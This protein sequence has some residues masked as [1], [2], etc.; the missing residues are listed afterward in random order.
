MD[1]ILLWSGLLVIVGLG[2]FG[3][4]IFAIRDNFQNKFWK[5]MTQHAVMTITPM[6]VATFFAFSSN[7]PSLESASG[8]LRA[9]AATAV[10]AAFMNVFYWL[11]TIA[12]EPASVFND[13]DIEYLSSI[14]IGK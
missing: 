6:F 13:D 7:Q 4:T 8:F 10:T 1:N 11:N 12:G 5:P 2:G 9:V 14:N 3:L